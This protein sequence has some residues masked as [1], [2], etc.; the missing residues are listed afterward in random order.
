M[1]HF[2]TLGSKTKRKDHREDTNE[3]SIDIRL[4]QGSTPN[5]FLFTVV[6]DELT[7]EIQEGVS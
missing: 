5:P 7:K 4:H 6:M 1:E 2:S 3:F